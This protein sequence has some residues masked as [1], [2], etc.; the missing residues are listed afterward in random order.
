[1]LKLTIR[2]WMLLGPSPRLGRGILGA[3]HY[4]GS[5]IPEGIVDNQLVESPLHG[6]R[7]GD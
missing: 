2:E 6:Q 3:S 1:M 5:A 7:Q 4:A